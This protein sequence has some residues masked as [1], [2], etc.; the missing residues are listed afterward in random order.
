MPADHKVSV[1][2][3][4]VA[5]FVPIA[6]FWAFYRIRKLRK[7]LVYVYLPSIVISVALAAY[8]YSTVGYEKPGDGGLGFGESTSPYDFVLFDPTVFVISGVV[9]WGLFGLS[10]YLI[11]KWSGEHNRRFDLPGTSG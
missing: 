3:Q 9:S 8:Y 4:I 1:A 5:L 6:N 11:V 7:Y 10:I 2:W